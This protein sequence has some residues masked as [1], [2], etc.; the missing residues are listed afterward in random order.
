MK[1][2]PLKGGKD[3]SNRKRNI[4]V[5]FCVTPEEKKIDPSKNDSFQNQEHGSIP[6]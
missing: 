6:S 2:E 1:M 4:Q 5:L 3:M